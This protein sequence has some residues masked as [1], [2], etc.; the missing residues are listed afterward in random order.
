MQIAQ[1]MGGYSLGQADLLRRAMGKKNAQVMQKERQ[2]FVEGAK[3][4]GVDP[5]LAGEIFDLMEMFAAYG[6]N[7]CVVGSTQVVDAATGARVRVDEL[8]ERGGGIETLSYDREAGAIVP[9]R[10]TDVMQNGE[11]PVFALTTDAG[12]RVVATGNHPFLTR[13]GWKWLEEL[14]VGDEVA[15]AQ[16]LPLPK[17]A[18]WPKHQLVAFAALAFGPVE[19]GEGGLSL[20]MASEALAEDFAHAATAFHYTEVEREGAT[21]RTR[22]PAPFGTSRRVG[23]AAARLRTKEESGLA[24]WA[25]ALGLPGT[26]EALPAELFT[27]RDADLELLLGRIWSAQGTLSATPRLLVGSDALAGDLQHLFTRLGIVT[28]IRH[29]HAGAKLVPLAGANLERFYHRIVPH[30]VGRREERKALSEQILAR[31]WSQ[32][33]GTEIHWDRVASIEARGV[34]MTYD[35]TV[36]QTHNFVA[37]GVVVHNSHSAAYALITMQTGWLKCHYPAEFM[38]ALLTSDADRT[39]KLVAHIANAKERGIEVLPPDINESAR[40]FHGAGKQIRFGMGGVKGVGDGAI[41]A[42]VEARE[43]KPFT[44]LFDFLE[45]VDLRKVN[46]KVVEFLVRCGAFDS[47]GVPRW[48]LFASIDSALER[49]QGAQ[50]DRAVGQGSLFGLLGGAESSDRSEPGKDGPYVE[51]EPWTDKELLAGEKELLGFYVTGHPLEPFLDEIKRYVTHDIATLLARG[52]AGDAVR[53]VGVTS[54]LRARTTKSGRLMGFATIEDLTGSI[55]VICFSGARRGGPPGRPGR[56]ERTGGFDTWQPLL[57]SDQPL[58]ISGTVQFNSR[59]EENPIP[60]LIADDVI[61]LAEIRAQRARALT[62]TLTPEIATEEAL[63]RAREL[64]V[65]HPGSLPVE[66]NVVLPGET[67]TKIRLRGVEVTPA[68][69]LQERLNLL[70]GQSV[71]EVV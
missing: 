46:R 12:K 65:A 52:R 22:C 69:D 2:G 37:D 27:L 34:E 60:E 38:A 64:L 59:D 28:K 24:S 51:A 62:L 11:K 36:D 63:L 66:V 57:E 5:K 44:G 70:F 4:N 42:I 25:Q 10:V 13:T 31:E 71:V 3:G 26:L 67:V 45:R 55:E 6:F 29:T 18:Q 21:V 61:P 32:E 53:I 40:S 50:R 14:Q 16:V 7:K 20:R 49:G 56:Q 30:V 1:V 15:T 48:R 35:L 9:R 54:A 33:D 68:D 58:L 39:D 17:G 19:R 23:G 47:V 43:E 8:Y 41:E